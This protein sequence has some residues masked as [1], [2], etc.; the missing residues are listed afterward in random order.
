[1]LDGDAVGPEDADIRLPF[2]PLQPGK[3]QSARVESSE[4]GDLTLRIER[5]PNVACARFR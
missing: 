3:A 4:T 2:V 1:M 5:I